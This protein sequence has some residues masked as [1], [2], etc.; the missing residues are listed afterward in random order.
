MEYGEVNDHGM[1]GS[2]EARHEAGADIEGITPETGNGVRDVDESIIAPPKISM[3]RAD[4]SPAAN[5]AG[6]RRLIPDAVSH[7]SGLDGE[8][9]RPASPAAQPS[10][11]QAPLHTERSEH[12]TPPAP[13]RSSLS[14]TVR[15]AENN[16]PQETERVLIRERPAP[17]VADASPPP[18]RPE[19][20]R[21]VEH[22]ELD[23]FAREVIE[24]GG[25]IP[26]HIKM[27]PADRAVVE[28][29]SAIVSD[30]LRRLM[31]NAADGRTQVIADLASKEQILA[32]MSKSVNWANALAAARL[33][34]MSV[35]DPRAF[36]ARQTVF[37]LLGADN[38]PAT[39]DSDSVADKGTLEDMVSKAMQKWYGNDFKG[40]QGAQLAPYLHAY[41]VEVAVARHKEIPSLVAATVLGF[42][43]SCDVTGVKARD[44]PAHFTDLRLGVRRAMGDAVAAT[45]EDV[46][47]MTKGGQFSVD[48]LADLSNQ[49]LL[50]RVVGG[51]FDAGVAYRQ[52]LNSERLAAAEAAEYAAEQAQEQ[53]RQAEQAAKARMQETQIQN[54]RSSL[55]YNY[56]AG[57]SPDEIS[58]R[59][60][61][62]AASK[63]MKAYIQGVAA[64]YEHSGV[65][66]P[67]A[68]AA[69]LA[70]WLE[71]SMDTFTDVVAYVEA[72]A[73]DMQI[74]R[75]PPEVALVVDALEPA[76]IAD[77]ALAQRVRRVQAMVTHR[78]IRHYPPAEGH[79]YNARTVGV[80]RAA[81]I[82][83]RMKAASETAIKGLE[84]AGRLKEMTTL[85]RI[86]AR[87][88]LYLEQTARGMDV[89]QA[90]FSPRL[91]QRILAARESRAQAEA[92]AQQPPRGRG[93]GR[94]ADLTKTRLAK[95]YRTFANERLSGRGR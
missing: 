77:A 30:N 44:Y 64:L 66:S 91:R 24:A 1:A 94:I 57:S 61:Q 53:A 42:D 38:G 47:Q 62:A 93:L 75:I 81:Y 16:H 69:L 52:T 73:P 74:G 51:C 34:E 19:P 31:P 67:G 23:S 17:E 76:E 33:L 85:Q 89:D 59:V 43:H 58:A 55:D 13:A 56:I 6:S 5:A 27:D 90:P 21:T 4:S 95:G 92:A 63:D 37:G 20:H 70:Q 83:D 26:G 8:G 82:V 86:D 7:R 12:S 78:S 54:S 87:R 84:Y 29:V 11:R 48:E 49:L 41:A 36:L 9:D 25:S 40:Q 14:D 71:A 72:L 3:A 32:S 80:A 39:G 45:R 65:G 46:M 79:R 15:A 10:H 35:E 28:T 60:D 50:D 88:L 22:K 68:E 2:F 18:D